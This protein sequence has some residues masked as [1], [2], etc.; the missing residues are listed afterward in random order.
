[1]WVGQAAEAGEQSRDSFFLS[2]TSGG[3]VQ[4]STG[5]N[6]ASSQAVTSTSHPTSTWFHAAAVFDI[7]TGTDRAAFLNGGGKGTNTTN[8]VPAGIDRTSIGLIDNTFASVPWGGAG[9][10]YIALPAIWNTNLTDAEIALLAAGIPPW[11]VRPESLVACWPMLDSANVG[12]EPNWWPGSYAMVEQGTLPLGV[13]NP[14]IVMPFPWSRA[15]FAQSLTL[16]TITGSLDTTDEG[17]DTAAG[18]GDVVAS[19][20]LATTDQGTDA[21]A[22]T[23]DAPIAGD[24]DTTDEGTDTFAGEGTVGDPAPVV[25][26]PTVG[27][28]FFLDLDKERKRLARRRKGE[29]RR[30]VLEDIDRIEN[31]PPAPAPER[32]RDIVTLAGKLAEAERAAAILAADDEEAILAILAAA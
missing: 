11:R 31:P 7:T 23:G 1:M 5:S 28:P 18:T 21:L 17:A 22:A 29:Q 13:G 2:T 15:P 30:R 20:A 26:T 10:G 9:T 3:V 12:N 27:D 16:D 8:R 14:P 6:T 25:D 32:S 19:G 4:A 24:L